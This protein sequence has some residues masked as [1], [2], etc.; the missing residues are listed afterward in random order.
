MLWRTSP[1]RSR[2]SPA[3]FI[4]PAQ[5]MLV[6]QPPAGPEWVHEVKHDGYRLLVR[7]QVVRVTLW[8]RHATHLT[9]WF[10]RIAQTV[11]ALPVDDVLLDGEPVVLRPG[12]PQRFCRAQPTGAQQ[13]PS[14]S[15]STSCISMVTTSARCP[16]E[17]RRAA[18]DTGRRDRRL[19]VQR[20]DR[21]RRRGRVRQGGRDGRG[22][23]ASAWRLVERPEEP[24]VPEKMSRLNGAHPLVSILCHLLPYERRSDR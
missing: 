21:G 15:P 23:S 6:P 24:G 7:K 13:S 9:D 12:G 1:A 19:P 16:L 4:L 17:V 18:L 8:S 11:R 3:G 14:L 22:S 5:P 2:R 10:P 20:G